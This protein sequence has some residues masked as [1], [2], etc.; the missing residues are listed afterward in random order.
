MFQVKNVLM[1]VGINT[2]NISVL[3]LT[4]AQS[5]VNTRKSRKLS[6]VEENVFSAQRSLDIKARKSRK[7]VKEKVMHS[8]FQCL[9]DYKMSIRDLSCIIVCVANMIFDQKW[10]LSKDEEFGAILMLRI[11]QIQ[12]A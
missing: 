9:A 6:Q 11:V 1:K 3:L 8:A 2:R 5:T 12:A 4:G 7:P 10:T